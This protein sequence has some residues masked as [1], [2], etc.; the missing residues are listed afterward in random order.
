MNLSDSINLVQI[1]AAGDDAELEA[2]RVAFGYVGPDGTTKQCGNRCRF[3]MEEAPYANRCVLMSNK[4]NVP[5]KASCTEY[6]KGPPHEVK[7]PMGLITPEQVGLVTGDVQCKRCVRRGNVEG[8]CGA[9]TKLAR[10]I[11]IKKDFKIEGDGCC[12]WNKAKGQ[13]EV[14]S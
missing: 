4:I 3:H 13:K 7:K 2:L 9:I 1:S 12:N 14:T 10:A 11:G 5:D 8:I 6:V